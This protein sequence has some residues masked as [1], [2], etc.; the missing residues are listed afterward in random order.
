MCCLPK[1]IEASANYL[2]QHTHKYQYLMSQELADMLNIGL[3]FH[4]ATVR[5]KAQVVE[6]VTGSDVSQMFSSLVRRNISLAPRLPRH[7][8]F[9]F[10]L[11][12]WNF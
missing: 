8:P 5:S 4:E 6:E 9:L 1:N 7:L 3:S 12:V 2:G 10:L 11:Q